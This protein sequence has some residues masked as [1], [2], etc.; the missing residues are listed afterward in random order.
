[1]NKTALQG[2]NLKNLQN[3]LDIIRK[4]LDPCIA[5]T[6]EQYLFYG[7][8]GYSIAKKAN[9]SEHTVYRLC[10]NVSQ[11]LHIYELVP[12]AEYIEKRI[13]DQKAQIFLKDF[14]FKNKRPVEKNWP[15]Y[16]RHKILKSGS[17]TILEAFDLKQKF[18]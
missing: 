9:Q 2:I 12:N 6:L 3:T 11:I 5:Y 18:F 1:M 4:N 14:F 17:S 15:R 13:H 8:T 10:K 7:E 16:V